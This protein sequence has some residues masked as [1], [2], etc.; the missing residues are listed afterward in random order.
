MGRGRGVVVVRA[1]HDDD[2][3]DN[4]SMMTVMMVMMIQFQ[5]SDRMCL[6]M[7]IQVPVDVDKPDTAYKWLYDDLW[8]SLL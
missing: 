2:D 7:V 5:M 8:T 4:I 1:I 6:L 3:D